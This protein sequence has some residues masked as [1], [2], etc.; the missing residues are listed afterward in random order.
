MHLNS[1]IKKFTCILLAGSTLILAG[2]GGNERVR[3]QTSPSVV[4]PLENGSEEIDSGVIVQGID[5]EDQ[6]LTEQ[7]FS[8][9]AWELSALADRATGNDAIALRLGAIQKFIA[10]QEYLA[11]ETQT[12]YLVGVQLDPEQSARFNLYRGQISSALDQ[13]ELALSYLLPLR[14]GIDLNEPDQLTLFKT[15]ANSQLSLDRKAEALVSLMKMDELLSIAVELADGQLENQRQIVSLLGTVSPPERALLVDF[16]SQSGLPDNLVSGWLNFLPILALSEQER[17]EP[18][19]RW[20]NAYAN[21]PARAELLGDSLPLSSVTLE[22]FNH[23]ALLLPLTSPFGNAAQAFYDGFIDS[24]NNDQDVYKPTVS[25]HDIGEDP[26][27]ATF[28]YQSAMNEGAD[29]IVGPLGRSAVVGLLSAAPLPLPTLVLGDIGVDQQADALY[30]IS[31]S[32]EL[33]AEQVA[34]RAYENGHRQAAIFR[35]DSSQG[36]RA[37][38]AFSKKWTELGGVIVTNKSFPS[39]IDDYSRIIQ[40]LLEVNQSVARER[41][42]SAQL[43]VNLEFNPRRRDDIDMLF[44]AG[45]AKQ[46]RLLVPQMRFFQAH[47]LPIYATSKIFSGKTNPAVDADLD[48]IIFGDMG[49]M[50]NLRYPLQD[51]PILDGAA[52]SESASEE[53][54]EPQPDPVKLQ[55]IAKSPYSFSPLDRLYALGLESYRLI[56]RLSSLRRDQRQQYNGEAFSARVRN[57]GNIIRLMDWATFDKGNISLIDPPIL[58][59]PQSDIPQQ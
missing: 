16:A 19:T 37:A 51:T 53:N 33:E 11:A 44:F 28:Y 45:D 43:G 25:L 6:I 21:H 55:P 12:N 17:L 20:A 52:S 1:P 5:P 22:R 54:P 13:H 15:L 26:G 2:C 10:M 24:H 4:A 58:T 42:L 56:P 57:D 48:E 27:L 32:P 50:L 38:S 30:G 59:E 3:P 31:L 41:V 36:S 9:D 18:L 40:R 34:I 23:V 14:S 47:D 29:F 35:S 8:E 46:A 39:T 7:I 49:W